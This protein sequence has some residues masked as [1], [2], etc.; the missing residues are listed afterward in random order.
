MI[1]RKIYQVCKINSF[2][3]GL[4][5]FLIS[6]LFLTAVSG[7][8][9]LNLRADDNQLVRFDRY[10]S[11]K[12]D[13][14]TFESSKPLANNTQN[15]TADYAWIQTPLIAEVRLADSV[16]SSSALSPDQKNDSLNISI[17]R[18]V[19]DPGHGGEDSGA[20]GKN[21]LI[22]KVVTLDLAQRLKKLLDHEKS[23]SVI[24]TRDKD[25]LVPLERRAEIANQNH[26]DM[27]ISIHA[28]ASKKR[29]ARGFETYFL[30]PSANEEAR[31][32]A[33]LENSSLRFEQTSDSNRDLPDI[34]FILMDLVQNEFLTESSDFASI[35]RRHF[36]RELNLP[37]RGVNQAG[38][39]VLNKAYMPAV[40]VETAFISNPEDEA[41]L[42]KDSFR[43]RVAQALF[44]SIKEFK[45]K[46]ESAQ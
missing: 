7:S 23:F 8:N 40:L 44:E 19:I 42:K 24:L 26:A 22:E 12:F 20:V 6:S 33:A 21:G 18:I 25:E 2:L 32:A 1:Q 37:D 35:I 28:N 31:I 5:V 39:M 41:L 43:Q 16:K 10:R 38:F 13:Q 3:S 45:R 9:I 29:S 27:F 36:K 17:E 11:E 14:T 30:S 4:F 15:L 46:Y 34:N